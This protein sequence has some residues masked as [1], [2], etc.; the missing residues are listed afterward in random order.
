LCVVAATLL[1]GLGSGCGIVQQ[2][3][4]RKVIKISIGL[5]EDSHE[6]QGIK[7]F[8][9]EVEKNSKGRYTVQ[10]YANAQLGDDVK[11]TEALRAGTLEMTVPST[12]P[13]T[14]ICREL[15]VFDLPF[16]FPSS[17]VAYAVL[18]G[19]VGRKILDNLAAKGVVG[20]AYWDNGFRH[21]TNSV[22]EI[23]TP[24]DVKGLK[25]RTMQN[26]MH[27][28]AWK[29]MGANPTPM[30]F[31]EIFL[32]MQTKKID[33]QENPVPTIYQQKFAE[34]QKYCTLTGH[35][36]TPF[37]VLISKKVWDGMTPEDQKIFRD[38]AVAAR[39]YERKVSADMNKTHVDMLRRQGMTVTELTAG[40]LKAFQEAVAPV[41]A[42]F[43]DQI[44]RETVQ[45]VQ[46]EVRKLTKQ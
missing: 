34:V 45:A 25:L 39:D 36:Y 37:V 11:A 14:G 41:A 13:L 19:P 21:L 30:P 40:Q 31:S 35:I 20:L 28:A 23:R 24:A 6:Y 8:K 16:I 33:G 18:D 43:A 22:R 12:S 2:D 42:M 10:L 17:E 26:E 7:K 15:G 29:A 1:A 44:G 5:N 38:A 9:E 46:D 27:L 4:P 3:A 32:A